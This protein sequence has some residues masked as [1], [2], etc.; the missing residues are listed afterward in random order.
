MRSCWKA[1]G[2]ITLLTG[3][4]SSRMTASEGTCPLMRRMAAA[5]EAASPSSTETGGTTE[6]DRPT[7][8][9]DALVSV[10][11]SSAHPVTTMAATDA[12][13]WDAVARQESTLDLSCSDE[14]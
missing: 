14:W 9:S 8:A 13:S 11:L 2:V 12:P 7:S 5:S 10:S 1:A 3:E 6:T 4:E